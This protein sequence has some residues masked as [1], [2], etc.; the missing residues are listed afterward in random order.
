MRQNKAHYR[1]YCSPVTVP[2]LLS[3]G[4]M[5]I[6]VICVFW[7][8][9][10]WQPGQTPRPDLPQS[11]MCLIYKQLNSV[12]NLPPRSFFSNAFSSFISFSTTF[13]AAFAALWTV[14]TIAWRDDGNKSYFYYVRRSI[15][16]LLQERY[17]LIIPEYLWNKIKGPT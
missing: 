15:C 13:F 7:P 8:G 16:S 3:R 11:H 12:D 5:E 14:V 2:L 4:E 10:L 9:L 6:D 17:S 1:A